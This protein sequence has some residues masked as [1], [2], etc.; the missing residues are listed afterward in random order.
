MAWLWWLLA[1]LASTVVGVGLLALRAR[2]EVQYRAA[3]Q[4]P[5]AGHRRLLAA[6]EPAGASAELPV[7]MR[8]LPAETPLGNGGPVAG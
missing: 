8:V 7:T 4:D 3:R 2:A 1:P 6:L 5:I